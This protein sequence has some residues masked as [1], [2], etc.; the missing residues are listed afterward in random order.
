MK[1]TDGTL[2]GILEDHFGLEP[3]DIVAESRIVED[4]GADSLDVVEL[5]MEIDEEFAIET[6]DEE[7]G[8][9]KTYGELLELVTKQLRAVEVT[10][11]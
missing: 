11:S 4:L 10:A 3:R 9:V 2:R 5:Q 1:D 6:T 8:K 7:Y